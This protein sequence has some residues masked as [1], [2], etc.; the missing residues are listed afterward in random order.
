MYLAFATLIA[1]LIAI[2][3][4]CIKEKMN[5]GIIAITFALVLGVYGAG[6]P[7]KAIAS[8]FPTDLF[9][10][11]VAICL[12]FNMAAQNG[13]LEKLSKLFIKSVNGNPK[14]FPLLFFILTFF[15]SAIGPGN[16]AATALMVPIG[17]AVAANASISSLLMAIM[18]CTGANAGAFSPIAPTG[19]IGIGLMDKI[20]VDGNNVAM[21][22]F[23]ASA[24]IQSLSAISAYLFFKGYTAARTKKLEE[25][26]KKQQ[27][28]QFS[29]PQL[30]TLLAIA[31]LVISVIFFKV[32]ISLMAF[33]LISILSFFNVANQEQAIKHIP[34]STILLVSGIS[35]LIGI[36][37]KTG[38]LD[39]ATSMIASI[40]SVNTINAMLA[41]ITGI[42]S[43]YSSSSGVVMP[44]FI[45]L[46]PGIIAKVGGGNIIEMIIAIAVGSHMV[47][48]SPL[49]TLGA[50]TIA[51]TDEK[52]NKNVLFRN[53]LLW[54]YAMAI[55]GALLAFIFL[56]LSALSSSILQ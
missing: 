52:E 39:L 13:T 30:A 12:L 29:R 18:I 27:L 9:L 53:L 47:D 11:L 17:M 19:I 50:L 16:I 49:S 1:L 44:A 41:L 42:V 23:L 5:T 48:V 36:M 3:I 28:E 33:I 10:M 37:E 55:V 6:M 34:W 7:I 20:G 56:D 54:G 43:A 45:P 32:N 21:T 38:G 46:I 14:L 4:G 51:A 22:V 31:I 40:S 35:I 2:I 8:S 15:L 24:S 25:F 26:L